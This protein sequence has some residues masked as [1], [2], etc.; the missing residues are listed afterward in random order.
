MMHVVCGK[1]KTA[2]GLRD[3]FRGRVTWC[4]DMLWHSQRHWF[5]ALV[6]ACTALPLRVRVLS[7]PVSTEA[8]VAGVVEDV[9]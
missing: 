7:G 8:S 1:E 3:Q 9:G 5:F 2:A 6:L 4:P